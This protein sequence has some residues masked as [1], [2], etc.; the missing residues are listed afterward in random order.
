MTEKRR[1]EIAQIAAKAYMR[2]MEMEEIPEDAKEFDYFL[3][4]LLQKISVDL[5]HYL[6]EDLKQE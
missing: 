1:R 4:V 6:G 3:S 2:V 5:A